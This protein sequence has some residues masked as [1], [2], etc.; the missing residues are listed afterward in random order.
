MQN[1]PTQK[2]LVLG[3]GGF[4]GQHVVRTLANNGKAVRAVSRR[5]S[6]K[7]DFVEWVR[8]DYTVQSF[9]DEVVQ[10]C[11]SCVQLITTTGPASSNENIVYDIESNVIG[12]VRL[13]QALNFAGVRKFVFLSSGG[14]V[15]GHPHYTPLNEDHPTNPMS[16]YGVTK[17][18]T[19]KFVRMNQVQNGLDS[20]ILR[21]S[22]PFGPGQR[23]ANGQGVIAAFLSKMQSG[24]PIEIW[25]DGTVVRDYIYIDDVVGAILAALETSTPE[26][27]INIGSGEGK[28]L[29]EVVDAMSEIFNRSPEIR[30]MPNRAVD[31]SKSVLEIARAKRTLGWSP[32]TSF[33]DALRLTVEQS[34]RRHR[35]APAF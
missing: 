10:G 24:E 25:G 8:G 26:P 34:V 15:Y 13:L 7:D 5:V 28:S 2:C 9:L 1:D 19:E 23:F 6:I 12:N 32:S 21:L 29:I 31:V 14:T 33:S 27:V 3:A 18:A 22:N 35:S 16:S 30:F 20:T 4:I 17:L 11:D